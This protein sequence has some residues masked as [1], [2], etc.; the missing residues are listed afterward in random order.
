ML[1]IRGSA[2]DNIPY[3]KRRKDCVGS[4]EFLIFNNCDSKTEIKP[5]YKWE[6]DT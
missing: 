1:N 3:M 5:G 2:S 6:L 4:V